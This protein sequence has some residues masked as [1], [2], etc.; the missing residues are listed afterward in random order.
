MAR[1]HL[2]EVH[3]QAWCP[4]AVRNG[5][6]DQ[7]QQSI[8]ILRLY[9]PIAPLLAQAVLRSRARRIVDLGAGAGGPW[10][11]LL[12]KL[13]EQVQEVL[14]TDWYP[15]T[16]AFERVAR[17]SGGRL[18]FH[19]EPVDAR[20]IPKEIDGFRTLF[21]SFHHFR[22]DDARVILQ[23]AVDDNVGIGVFEFTGRN[24]VSF[25]MVAAGSLIVAAALTPL[26]RPFRWSRLFWTY[27]IPAI[28]LAL[29]VDGLVSCLRTY[30]PS[31]LRAL[32]DQVDAPHYEW[33][34]G[35]IRSIVPL[36]ITYL[37]GYPR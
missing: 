32:V 3:E 15:N 12:R 9:K 27:V 1:A 28:P 5:V 11:Y 6:T 18:R 2:I 30:S 7:L 10:P 31:E 23:H 29:L 33:Q 8:T 14:L 22:T 36:P 26:T 19:P 35:V 24:P 17:R 25:A 34:I 13:P 16:L 37:I 21:T 20:H 4:P